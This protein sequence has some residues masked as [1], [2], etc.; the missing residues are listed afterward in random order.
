MK[1]CEDCINFFCETYGD[2]WNEPRETEYGCKHEDTEDQETEYMIFK[3][4]ENNNADQCNLYDSGICEICK[5]KIGE[6]KVFWVHG[7]YGDRK[8]CSEK[9]Q[10]EARERTDKE[11]KHLTLN[12]Y[13]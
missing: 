12:P 5:E 9:C 4:L 10:K 13:I 3:A 2:G 11:E 8:C 6:S 7:V 1:K